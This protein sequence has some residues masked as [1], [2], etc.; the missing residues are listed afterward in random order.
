VSRLQC[1]QAADGE[2]ALPLVA[3]G[4]Y[5]Q[6]GTLLVV[7]GDF[8][9]PLPVPT[10][11]QGITSSPI[12]GLTFQQAQ[13]ALASGKDP[14]PYMTTVLDVNAEANIITALICHADGRQPS[15]VCNRSA[16]KLILKHFK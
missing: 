2:G 14:S 1:L 3:I 8:G 16:V 13:S 6:A 11:S 9:K 7:V 12:T 15:S 10:A 5:V 4:G